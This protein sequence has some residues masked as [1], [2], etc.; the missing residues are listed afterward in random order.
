MRAMYKEEL[1]NITKVTGTSG[2]SDI[3]VNI[4]SHDERV[5]T[6]IFSDRIVS[7]K[8]CVVYPTKKHRLLRFSVEWFTPAHMIVNRVPYVTNPILKSLRAK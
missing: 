2:V 7:E 1:E 5:R 4:Y 6:Y 3:C 8:R